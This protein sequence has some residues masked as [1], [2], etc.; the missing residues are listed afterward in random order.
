M[1][2]SFIM[3]VTYYNNIKT[4]TVYLTSY[5]HLLVL[6]FICSG[7]AISTYFNLNPHADN[8][9][10]PVTG[11]PMLSNTRPL[12]RYLK[13]YLVFHW[14]LFNLAINVCGFV[15]VSYWLLISPYDDDLYKSAMLTYLTVD[16]HGF[17]FCIVLLEFLFCSTPVKL[18]HFIYPSCFMGLYFIINA[19]YWAC[20]NHQIY[21]DFLDYGSN[22]GLAVGMVI[23]AVVVAMPLGH[24]CWFLLHL[25]KERFQ[26]PRVVSDFELT[27]HE[28]SKSDV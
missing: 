21:G 13:C 14:L 8:N 3:A 16:R 9:N 20:T 2:I 22:T 18:L 6:L 4:W 7:A 19:I 26:K 11:N 25:V 10:E 27:N 28:D 24:L 15:F 23:A 12:N 5:N 1:L 17:N